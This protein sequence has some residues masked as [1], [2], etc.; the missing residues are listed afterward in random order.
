MLIIKCNAPKESRESLLSKKKSIGGVAVAAII[1]SRGRAAID[2]IKFVKLKS[3]ESNN[4]R[5]LYNITK[6]LFKA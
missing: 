2:A 1:L 4:R 6:L 5:F 3:N